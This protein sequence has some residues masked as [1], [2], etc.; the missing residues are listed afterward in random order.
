M[1]SKVFRALTAARIMNDRILRGDPRHV[2]LLNETCRVPELM[3]LTDDQLRAAIEEGID[4]CGRATGDRRY[5]GDPVSGRRAMRT[6]SHFRTWRL[7]LLA[8]RRSLF[9]QRDEQAHAAET[10]FN[11]VFELLNANDDD[12]QQRSSR[13]VAMVLESMSL[14]HLR[15]EQPMLA[16]VLLRESA[17]RY[18]VWGAVGK[19]GCAYVV[20]SAHWRICA[21]RLACYAGGCRL[22]H[23]HRRTKAA[24]MRTRIDQCAACRYRA[25]LRPTATATLRRARSSRRRS[26]SRAV[27]TIIPTLSICG[28]RYACCRC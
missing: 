12:R 11:A 3:A 7:L 13:G 10:T 27:A 6:L 15:H 26:G 2:Q 22:A 18:A 20:G 9:P 24:C 21:R 14:H 28:R 5:V 25:A 1:H 4:T 23:S 16:D 17:R 8:E 19:V